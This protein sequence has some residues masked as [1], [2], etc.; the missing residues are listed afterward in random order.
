MRPR[1]TTNV[2]LTTKSRAKANS[3]QAPKGKNKQNDNPQ[4]RLVRLQPKVFSPVVRRRFV[5]G[6]NA[7][8]DASGNIP[9]F[10]TG[11][12]DVIGFLGTEWSNFAQE[13][14]EFRVESLGYWFAPATTNATSSAGPYQGGI[15]AA[16]W[17]QLKPV[18]AN[19]LYQSNE[20]IKFS[21]L[22]EKE[23]VVRRPSGANFQL[24]TAFGTAIPIDRDYGLS[25]ISAGTLA[26]SSKIYTVVYEVWA[27]FK[28][29]Y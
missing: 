1:G 24:W 21:T 7:N 9:I 8:S 11:C 29:P 3:K 28:L 23:V 18:S 25:Y 15:L 17:A 14:S 10:A 5:I 27:E 2:S 6:T 13:F 26:T 16:P 20:I 12:A 22:E 19:S 4:G